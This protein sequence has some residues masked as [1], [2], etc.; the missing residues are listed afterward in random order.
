MSEVGQRDGFDSLHQRVTSRAGVDHGE[1]DQAK[2]SEG[3]TD[4]SGRLRRVRALDF[5]AIQSITA[6]E[7]EID[8][9]PLIGGPEQCLVVGFAEEHLL[10]DESLPGSADLGMFE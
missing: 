10:D 3:G 1:A 4:R 9:C 6:A 5:H 8:L 7:D 2:F